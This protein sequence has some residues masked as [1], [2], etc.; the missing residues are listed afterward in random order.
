[1]VERDMAAYIAIPLTD[2]QVCVLPFPQTLAISQGVEIDELTRHRVSRL[3]PMLRLAAKDP[4]HLNVGIVGPQH[5]YAVHA[6]IPIRMELEERD[7]FH[8]VSVG[9]SAVLA[10]LRSSATERRRRYRPRLRS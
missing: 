1:D 7:T 6:D 9:E 2:C 8:G 4:V 5:V 3:N 10:R